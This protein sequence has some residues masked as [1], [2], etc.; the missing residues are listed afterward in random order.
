METPE[1]EIILLSI[2]ADCS[3][4]QPGYNRFPGR[5]AALGLYCLAGISPDRI[6]V[7]E[8]AGSHI[9]YEALSTVS[10]KGCRAIVCQA[11]ED[12]DSARMAGFCQ[13]LRELMP[14]VALGVNSETPSVPAGFDFAVNGTG[15]SAVLRILRGDR[16]TGFIDCSKEDA[17]SPLVVPEDP[18]IDIG[19]DICPEKWLYGQTLEIFQPWLGLSDRSATLRTWP[20]VDWVAGLV[21][22]LKRSGFASF[23]FRPSGLSCDDLHELRSMMLNLKARF[24]VSFMAEDQV[25]IVQIGRPLQQVW[26]YVSSPVSSETLG[27][28]LQQ[29][30]AA[31][32]QAGL[33]ISHG[34]CSVAGVAAIFAFVDRLAFSDYQRWP[35]PEMKRLTALYWGGKNRFLSRLVSIRSAYELVMFMKT[36]YMLLETVLSPDPKGR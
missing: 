18:L 25:K 29:I 21:T 36:S 17:S 31:D 5:P 11:Y 33:Q 20:G 9:A 10:S 4:E 30:H 27:E 35:F 24:A 12:S 8:A 28:R 13:R 32:F 23:H 15:K 2:P 34:S 26:L 19:Y 6:S 7:I 16:L 1:T 22:W 3:S 14:G